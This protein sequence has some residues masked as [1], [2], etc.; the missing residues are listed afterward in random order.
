MLNVGGFR[1]RGG[2]TL[3][4][5]SSS[6]GGFKLH[7]EV[8]LT[9]QSTKVKPSISWSRM[10]WIYIMLFALF[11]PVITIILLT[12][13]EIALELLYNY[14]SFDN[15]NTEIEIVQKWQPCAPSTLNSIEKLKS[16]TPHEG[17]K[18]RGMVACA[19]PI[20][21]NIYDLLVLLIYMKNVFG[22]VLPM[23]IYHVHEIDKSMVSNVIRLSRL[24]GVEI[25]VI[26]ISEILKK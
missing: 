14:S 8:S 22:S 13:N 16:K 10:K 24:N 1:N 23:E 18:T 19:S 20:N 6:S 3:S 17:E 2:T 5:S 26:D 21:Q 25:H 9:K 11:G 7:N 4:V 15:S 12:I